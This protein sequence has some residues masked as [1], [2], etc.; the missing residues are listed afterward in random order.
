[1]LFP[2]LAFA[3]TEVSSLSVPPS[4]LVWPFHGTS[5]ANGVGGWASS[6]VPLGAQLPFSSMRLGPDTSV[7]WEGIDWWLIYNH[8][9]GYFYND[10][11]IRAFSHTH[12]QGAGLGDG[13][14]VGVMMTRP[15]LQLTPLV[16]NAS[17]LPNN[18][19]QAPYRALFDHSQETAAP[20][21]YS[22]NLPSISTRIDLTATQRTGFTR[23]MCSDDGASHP[24]VLW[25]DACHRNHDHPCA[26]GTV[27]LRAPADN[28]TAWLVEVDTQENGSF[29]G[30]CGG[31]PVFITLTVN[32]PPGALLGAGRWVDGGVVSGLG[33]SSSNGTLGSLGVYFVF[34]A[35]TSTSNALEVEVRSAVSH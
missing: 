16:I 22:V 25:V 26:P 21:Y 14:A 13:G 17:L 10:S 7:C 18:F 11:C 33:T 32:S 24:C 12:V 5:G 29:G 4:S 9:G 8:Y 28:S 15:T 27:T 3:L 6:E 23:F 19:N 1:M 35:P 20:G 30:D 34:Q 2:L 31:V